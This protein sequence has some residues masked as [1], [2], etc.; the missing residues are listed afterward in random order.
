MQVA[1]A[2]TML[3]SV[4][5]PAKLWFAPG[6]PVNVTVRPSGAD[7]VL[8]MTDFTGKTVDPKSPIEVAAGA[9]KTVDLGQSYQQMNMIG[10]YVLYAL[11]KDAGGNLAKFVG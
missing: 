2:L 4:L 7:V 6:Q 1:S 9:E 8:V 11:P 5:F 3:F 10:T